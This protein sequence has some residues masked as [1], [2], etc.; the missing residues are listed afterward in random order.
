MGRR[1]DCPTKVLWRCLQW[2]VTPLLY[3]ASSPSLLL[4][5]VVVWTRNPRSTLLIR[6]VWG[7]YWEAGNAP[8]L[9]VGTLAQNQIDITT[10]RTQHN[11]VGIE[12]HVSSLPLPLAH[13]RAVHLSHYAPSASALACSLERHSTFDSECLEKLVL[14]VCLGEISLPSPSSNAKLRGVGHSCLIS[15]QTGTL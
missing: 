3:R 1:P 10:D 13:L 14:L 9:A 11:S 2:P 5:V 8:H 6:P 12:L 4:T 15:R 7:L